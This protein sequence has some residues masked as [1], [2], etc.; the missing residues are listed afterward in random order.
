MHER[1]RRARAAQAC[2]DLYLNQPLA[3]GRRD[4]ITLARTAL[5]KQGVRVPRALKG[6]RWSSLGTAVRRLNELGFSDLDQVIDAVGLAEISPASAWP[7]DIVAL[8][9]T[10]RQPFGCALTI[11]VGN[12][13]LLGFGEG[14][15]LCGIL[16]PNQFHKAWR[17]A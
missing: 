2:V 10:D 3:W 6:V 1:N 4:C 17:V 12:G 5:H 15:D 9:G 16:K 11:A 8:P 7:G 13:K 14:A